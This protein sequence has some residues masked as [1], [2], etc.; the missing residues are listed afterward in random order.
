MFVPLYRLVLFFVASACF[1]RAQNPADMPLRQVIELAQEMIGKGD[2]A[3]ASPM[4]D[5]LE[6]RELQVHQAWEMPLQNLLFRSFLGQAQLLALTAYLRDFVPARNMQRLQKIKR[7][8][9]RVQTFFKG[10]D[11]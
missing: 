10:N 6:V 4:L 3:G 7:D 9:I 2:F 8:D 5:E 11:D 1:L